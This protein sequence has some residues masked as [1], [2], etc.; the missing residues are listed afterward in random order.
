MKCTIVYGTLSGSTMTAA[1]VVSEALKAAG[2][3]VTTIMADGA[4]KDQLKDAQAVLFGS[5]SWEDEGKDGQPLPDVSRFLKTLTTEDLAGKKVAIFG[6]GDTSYQ[7]FCGAVDVMTELL[8][9]LGVTL[10]SE[11]LRVDRYYSLPDNETKTRA[12]AQNLAK[13]L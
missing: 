6:L 7:H 12:W 10:V 1:N 3:E 2:H 13:S 4:S 8:K 11:P 9:T 5:P